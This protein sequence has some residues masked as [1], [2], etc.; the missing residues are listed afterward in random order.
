MG[1]KEDAIVGLNALTDKT[2]ENVK[3]V[4][5]HYGFDSFER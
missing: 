5:N 4:L 3:L 1:R 2:I